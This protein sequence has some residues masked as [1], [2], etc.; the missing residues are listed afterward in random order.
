MISCQSRDRAANTPT[1][2]VCHSTR[3]QARPPFQ[4]AATIRTA[5]AEI[6]IARLLC[7]FI[8]PFFWCIEVIGWSFL[9]LGNGSEVRLVAKTRPA[10]VLQRGPGSLT[11]NYRYI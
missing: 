10:M 9:M 2:S 11:V 3:E 7:L 1:C 4:E 8:D 6:A 5:T